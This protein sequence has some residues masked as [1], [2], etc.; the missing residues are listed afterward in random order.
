MNCL[1]FFS[2][3]PRNYIFQRS[4]N[5]TNFGGVCFI[6]YCV[7]ILIIIIYYLIKYGNDSK[8]RIEYTSYKYDFSHKISNES[9]KEFEFEYVLYSMTADGNN[10][11]QLPNNF[12][13]IKL[14]PNITLPRNET[15]YGNLEEVDYL[16]V[17]ECKDDDCKIEEEIPLNRFYIEFLFKTDAF[18]LQEDNPIII[19]KF[20]YNLPIILSGFYQYIYYLEETICTT[21]EF[22][23]DKNNYIISPKEEKMITGY[24]NISIEK[25]NKKYKPLGQI[26]FYK[27]AANWEHYKR[28]RKSPLDTFANICS[29]GMTLLNVVKT[30]FLF[31]Y[32]KNFD[33][34]KIV[35]NFFFKGDIKIKKD[36]IESKE[37]KQLNNSELLLDSLNNDDNNID[38]QNIN[39]E[40]I[41]L[42]SEELI[43]ES[44]ILL[45]KLSFLSF[46]LNNIYC[47]NFCYK[48]NQILI[49][50]CNEIIT[51]YFSIENII[52]N[53]IKMENLLKDYKWNDQKLNTLENIELLK[54]LKI[55]VKN[56][57]L[58]VNG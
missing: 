12:N 11:K 50:K 27:N 13:L 56:N 23:S 16:L 10:I 4:S 53:Q 20:H 55:F 46:I 22:F 8:Y 31:L 34:Y 43:D 29:L 17:Y 15:L 25:D 48:K 30:L 42:V 36:K 37:M 26:S 40:Q 9:K 7:A 57:Y 39:K 3:S 2:D 58:S 33:N 49:T 21:T 32:S 41:K 1:D 24:L 5:K 35:Q 38:E 6:I 52:L 45:P 47:D 44:D 54:N 51:K 28:T 14:G 18:S 19:G